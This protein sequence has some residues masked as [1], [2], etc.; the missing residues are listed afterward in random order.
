MS[1]KLVVGNWKMNGSVESN[2]SLIQ[3]VVKNSAAAGAVVCPPL[4][5]LSQVKE[6]L[7]GSGIFLG[8]QN[9]SRFD[10]GAYTG[11]VSAGML[12]ECGVRHVLVGHSERRALFGESDAD[13]AAKVD[14][15]LA[16]D[17][18]PVVCV[19]ETLLQRQQGSAELLVLAQLR[20]VLDVVG[21]AK[22]ARCLV[23]YEPVWAIGTGVAATVA[24]VQGM[25]TSIKQ[26]F[27]EWS[28]ASVPVLYGG[29]V[30]PDNA[31]ELMALSVVDGALVGGASL[32][33]EQ[34]LAICRAAK[35][36]G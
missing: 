21:A 2:R 17:L 20:A 19:G 14:A 27:A 15:A 26:A 13:V 29:S 8:A 11:E 4:V 22:F 18:V 1:A 30:K 31:G 34:F 25:H 5:F 12:R 24:D 3:S 6:L 35:S 32:V 36:I 28:V 9:L 7:Q 16:K 33:A 10:H 23:A